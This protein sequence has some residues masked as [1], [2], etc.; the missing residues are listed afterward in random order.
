MRQ[1]LP[2]R[3]AQPRPDSNL[4]RGRSG[5]DMMRGSHGAG[6]ADALLALADFQLGDARVFDQLDQCLELA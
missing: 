2:E 6:D 4:L 1:G 3:Q 5:D